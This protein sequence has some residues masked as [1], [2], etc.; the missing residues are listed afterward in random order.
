MTSVVADSLLLCKGVANYGLPQ[1]IRLAWTLSGWSC[2]TH[3]MDDRLGGEL[4]SV[5][6]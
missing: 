6:G 5:S 3:V 1:L 2:Q 4:C